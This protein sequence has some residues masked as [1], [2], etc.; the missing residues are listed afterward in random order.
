M[1]C[2]RQEQNL[3]NPGLKPDLRYRQ[4]LYHL[5]HQGSLVGHL[6]I[7]LNIAAYSFQGLANLMRETDIHRQLV[8]WKECYKVN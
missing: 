7:S 6:T 2:S 4:I 8:Q 3:P 1:K 5:G